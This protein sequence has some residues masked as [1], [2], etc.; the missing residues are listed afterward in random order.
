MYNDIAAANPT[1]IQV[2]DQ[3]LENMDYYG[4]PDWMYE[5]WYM[6]NKKA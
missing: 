3:G 5:G 2:S 4:I 1:L 6:N